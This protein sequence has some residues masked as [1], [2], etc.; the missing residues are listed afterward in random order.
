MAVSFSA[1]FLVAVSSK[2][3]LSA[4][5]VGEILSV[6]GTL[7]DKNPS[8][9]NL[10]SNVWQTIQERYVNTPVDETHLFYGAISGLVNSLGDPYSVFLDP[11]MTEEFSHELSGQFEGIGAEI[12]IKSKQLSVIA[13]LPNTPAEKAGLKPGDQIIKIDEHETANLS[14]DAA[15]ALI[16]GKKGTKV[17][18]TIVRPPDQKEQVVEITRD[19]IKVDSVSWTMKSNN[20]AYIKISQFD[21]HTADDFVAAVREVMLKSPSGLILDLR[22]NPGGYLDAAIR[23]ADEFLGHVVV[24]QEQFNKGEAPQLHYGD[25]DTPLKNIPSAVLVNGGSA[26]GSEIVAGALQDHKAS[27]II[28]ERTFGKGSVQELEDFPDGSSLKLTVAKWLTPNGTSITDHGINPDVQVSLTQEDAD[29]GRDP[30]LD[31]AVEFILAK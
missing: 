28:G 6:V 5:T 7:Y 3:Q 1:G 15:V 22:N 12:G 27:I 16:R 10:F 19:S 31:K 13:P 26:S 2:K 29:A 24:V 8:S 18:L 23:V 9:K 14:I 11:Q 21:D 20:V 25:E 4:H 30:Q 17:S